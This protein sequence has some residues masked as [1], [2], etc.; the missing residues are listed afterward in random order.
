MQKTMSKK[1]DRG[2]CCS[3]VGAAIVIG[4]VLSGVSSCTH[5][6]VGGG[7][8]NHQKTYLTK[9]QK[10][11]QTAKKKAKQVEKQ[12]EKNHLKQLK[13]ALFKIPNKTKGTITEAKLDDDGMSVT[14]TLSDD[15]LN[16]SNAQIRKIAKDAWQIGIEY[17]NKYAPYP[18]GKV[19]PDTP[20]VYVEDSAGN[21]LG[22]SSAFGGFKWEGGN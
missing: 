12:N 13:T 15:C 1:S 7:E 16:G 6:L 2:G 11:K 8:S 5:H 20:L 9:K 21:E 3:I 10:T 18:D 4:L 22:R 14:I 17:I 19:N